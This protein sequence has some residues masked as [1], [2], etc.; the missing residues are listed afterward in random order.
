MGSLQAAEFESLLIGNYCYVIVIALIFYECALTIKDEIQFFWWKKLT[1]ATMLFW[2][3]KWLIIACCAVSLATC[4]KTSNRVC[5]L[6]LSP[7]G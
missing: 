3:N 4:F 7:A 5:P 1:G 2:L 6:S